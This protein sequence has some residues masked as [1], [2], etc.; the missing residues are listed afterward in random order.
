MP[1]KVD[2]RLFR[3]LVQDDSSEDGIAFYTRPRITKI[4]RMSKM[5]P[6]VPLGA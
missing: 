1:L 5:V 4:S 3:R 2:S 6:T